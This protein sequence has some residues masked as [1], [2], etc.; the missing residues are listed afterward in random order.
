[1]ENLHLE[2]K[3]KFH[4]VHGVEHN[5]LRPMVTNNVLAGH[6]PL[7]RNQGIAIST[8]LVFFGDPH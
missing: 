5:S 1:M 2:S 8:H 3:K 4:E 7:F 6:L